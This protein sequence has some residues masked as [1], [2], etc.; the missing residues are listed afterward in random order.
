M[1]LYLIF[2]VVV[3]LIRGVG[4]QAG[5]WSGGG[6]GREDPGGTRYWLR[7]VP[8]LDLGMV[9]ALQLVPKGLQRAGPDELNILVRMII[10]VTV[11]L[12]VVSGGCH[13]VIMT[14]LSVTIVQ[15]LLTHS[16]HTPRLLIPL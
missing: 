5:G 6:Q 16:G 14:V 9:M 2:V 13:P 4:G 12:E 3:F 15:R 7:G 10:R 1:S 11:S 8:G